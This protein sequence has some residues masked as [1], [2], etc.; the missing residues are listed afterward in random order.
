MKIALSFIEHPGRWVRATVTVLVASA[1]A[2]L[3]LAF[4]AAAA[5]HAVRSELPELRERL[6]KAGPGTKAPVRTKES[7]ATLPPAASLEMLR[8]R[9]A[10]MNA[11]FG[12]TG[13]PLLHNLVLF[14]RL[15]PANARLVS[16]HQASETGTVTIV[17]EAESHEALAQFLQNLEGSGRFAEVLLV[18]QSQHSGRGGSVRRFELRLKERA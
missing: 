11:L 1:V 17:A 5:A 9:V 14:E 12:H 3:A 13:Q 6:A 8:R 18:R 7:A 15:L 10:G 4:W 16:L 2:L